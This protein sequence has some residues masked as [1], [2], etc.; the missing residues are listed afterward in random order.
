[1]GGSATSVARLWGQGNNFSWIRLTFHHSAIF[2]GVTVSSSVREKG[3]GGPKG[4]RS[5]EPSYLN[6]NT[7]ASREHRPEK[8]VSHSARFLE[9]GVT[10][11]R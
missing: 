2:G 11:H 5:L 7:L 3:G 8:N 9:G 1:M 4:K 6:V 10:S